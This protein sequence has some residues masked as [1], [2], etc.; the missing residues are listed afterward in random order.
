MYEFFMFLVVGLGYC[1]EGIVVMG[2]VRGAIFVQQTLKVR[3]LKAENRR[4]LDYYRQSHELMQ[5]MMVSSSPTPWLTYPDIR[6]KATD[7]FQLNPL[8]GD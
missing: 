7:L 1:A 8:K 5:S 2:L 6:D 4:L 3:K